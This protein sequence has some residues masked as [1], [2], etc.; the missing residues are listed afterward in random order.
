MPEDIERKAMC[1][2]IQEHAKA[3]LD[4]PIDPEIL[5]GMMQLDRQDFAG[6]HA[7]SAQPSGHG[8]TISQPF[9]VAMMTDMV[10][11]AAHNRDDICEIVRDSKL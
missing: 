2:T 11:Q 7:D 8:Q 10:L 9:M 5:A 1:A 3:Y 4:R 6:T